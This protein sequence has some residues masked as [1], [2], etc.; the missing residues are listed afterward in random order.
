MNQ[1]S[2]TFYAPQS[3]ELLI[4]LEARQD[5][6]IRELDELNDRIE[7]AIVFGQIGV[8]PAPAALSAIGAA[9]ETSVPPADLEHTAS[10]A[11]IQVPGFV[12]RS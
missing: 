7:Q 4:D 12:D 3:A 1:P 9:P 11:A 5:N 8:R 6:L 10:L 2:A